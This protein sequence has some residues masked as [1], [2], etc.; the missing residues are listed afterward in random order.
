MSQL[1]AALA[2]DAFQGADRK[3]GFRM[4]DRYRAGAIR[5]PEMLVAA[6]LPDLLPASPFQAF[7]DLP[8]PHL[9]SWTLDQ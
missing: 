6:A 5:V 3:V 1:Y 8:A 2:L 9:P 4:R 7:Q